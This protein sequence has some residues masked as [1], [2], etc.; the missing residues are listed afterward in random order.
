MDPHEK[1]IKILQASYFRLTFWCWHQRTAISLINLMESG[2]ASFCC[3]TLPYQRVLRLR[4]L[5]IP[6]CRVGEKL[7]IWGNFWVGTAVLNVS[8]NGNLVPIEEE[9]PHL[10]LFETSVSSPVCENGERRCTFWRGEQIPP[11]DLEEYNTLTLIKLCALPLTL[12]LISR[13]L[14]YGPTWP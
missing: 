7:L 8:Q 11:K 13:S 5:T 10:W 9:L 1:Y 14:S 12:N 4:C 2:I 6:L 3:Q